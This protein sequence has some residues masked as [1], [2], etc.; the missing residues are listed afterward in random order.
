MN[1]DVGWII[2]LL[3]MVNILAECVKIIITGALECPDSFYAGKNMDKV[4]ESLIAE[5]EFWQSL[6]TEWTYS[7]DSAEYQ[8]IR[9]ALRFAQL[10]LIRYEQQ[11]EK[12][13]NGTIH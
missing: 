1:L 11:L 2:K 6:I 8:R 4:H 7:S 13:I 10:Q 12:P 3:S 5:V 9:D